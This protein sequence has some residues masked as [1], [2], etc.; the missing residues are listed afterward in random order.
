MPQALVSLLFGLS[1]NVWIMSL[2]PV[3]AQALDNHSK[4]Q[5]TDTKLASLSIS[6]G[7]VRRGF[8]LRH[9]FE[10]SNTTGDNW[11]ITKIE[12]DCS[13]TLGQ[14]S[15]SHLNPG[16]K[17]NL[18]VSITTGAEPGPHSRLIS[19]FV[20]NGS[21]GFALEYRVDYVECSLLN[22]ESSIEII[23][24]GEIPINQLPIERNITI[25]RGDFP[26]E[27]DNL[28]IRT[29]T[30]DAITAAIAPEGPDTW[31][32]R[33]N[34]GISQGG[35]VRGK[36]EFVPLRNGVPVGVPDER[37]VLATIVGA[38]QIAPKFLL[39]GVAHPGQHFERIIKVKG[40]DA[41]LL[42]LSRIET[43]KPSDQNL[44][45]PPIVQVSIVP[46]DP[47]KST[48]IKLD[49]GA[50]M[51]E[52]QIKCDL[53]FSA[54]TLPPSELRVPLLLRVIKNLPSTPDDFATKSM[55]AKS[56]SIEIVASTNTLQDPIDIWRQG[57]H[58]NAIQSLLQTEWSNP[59]LEF[60]SPLLLMTEDQ[61][62]AL[63]GLI[64]QRVS[65]DAVKLTNDIRAL[66][67]AARDR[68]KELYKSGKFE[69][70][71]RLL[72]AINGLG[73]RLS[74][75][76]RRLTVI[77]MVGDMIQQYAAEE[78]HKQTAALAT[79]TLPK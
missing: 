66:F 12:P 34:L 20:E 77:K 14:L 47:T 29:E 52:G 64:R 73:M 69:E 4:S 39:I 16:E 3:T 22:W 26:L 11:N 15:Q 79:P 17:T 63:D 54:Q 45:A 35:P 72:N 50:P 8:V 9:N 28:A 38:I 74:E 5:V 2:S 6:M 48:E 10:I 1:L 13:C 56:K 59:A 25:H 42:T 32:L 61:F 44:Q 27:F 53:V 40:I 19:V 23:N 60:T 36:F 68:A 33:I 43:T 55:A 75:P 41:T 51:E 31:T 76:K 71:N 18:D 62:G 58:E 67:R 46:V 7:R 57:Q 70:S 21:R 78:L 24:L 30:H 37:N 49:I 65:N